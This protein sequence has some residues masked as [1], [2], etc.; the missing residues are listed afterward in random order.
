MAVARRDDVATGARSS[1]CV[2]CVAGTSSTALAASAE[3]GGDVTGSL[4][5]SAGAVSSS[6]ALV[7]CGATSGSGSTTNTGTSAL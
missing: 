7:E 5:S 3:G 2:T 6:C 4:T 1:V